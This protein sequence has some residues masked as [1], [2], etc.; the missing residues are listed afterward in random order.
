MTEREKLRDKVH[1]AI[2]LLPS[3]LSSCNRLLISASAEKD[4]R[5]VGLAYNGSLPGSPHCDDVGHYMI[6]GHC[7]R[8]RHAERNLK[9]NTDQ[10]K[11]NGSH[12]RVPGTPCLDC[13]KELAG[14]HVKSIE[15]MG[16]YDNQ[17]F[18]PTPEMI[19][20]IFGKNFK[21]THRDLD[22]VELFQELFDKLSGPGG[23]FNRL[24]YRIKLVKEPLEKKQKEE[25]NAI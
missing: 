5:I 4:K 15:Y 24:G 22:W 25:T 20:E 18:Q 12:I 11:L 14:G 16:H 13:L 1:W 8:T 17:E 6:G 3:V 23:M 9:D 2:T 10:Q 7:K 19:R 21:L